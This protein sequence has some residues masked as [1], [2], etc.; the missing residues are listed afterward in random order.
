M[1]DL[2]KQIYVALGKFTFKGSYNLLIFL[3]SLRLVN[4][5]IVKPC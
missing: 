4:I 3:I 1:S 5:Q 2:V